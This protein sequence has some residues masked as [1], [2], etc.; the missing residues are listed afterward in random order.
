MKYQMIG[1][2]GI[3]V[4]RIAFGAWEVGGGTAWDCDDQAAGNMVA[5]L[6]D[7]GINF[8]D[9]AKVYGT[10]RSEELLGKALKGKRHDFI[11]ASKGGMN[12]RDS[13]G[14]RF[15]YD[16]DGRSVYQ[17][18]SPK[19]L[20]LDLEESLTRLDTDYLDL[21][22]THRQPITVPIADT[23]GAL[24]RFK[25]EGKIRAIGISNASIPQLEEYLRYGKVDV[26][27][28]KFSLFDRGE[29]LDYISFCKEHGITF[30]AYSALERGILTDRFNAQTAVSPGQ[31][32]Y[33]MIWY[34]TERRKDVLSLLD[35]LKSIAEGYGLSVSALALSYV[36]TW[37]EHINAICGS[38]KPEHLS[39]S[40]LGADLVLPQDTMDRIFALVDAL[41]EKYTD[42]QHRF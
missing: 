1:T 18:T 35:K 22:F 16:R 14:E 33:G 32:A 39:Q 8:I 12:W 27:Q 4:S 36:L 2:S 13:S 30:Q 11:L 29:V 24:M 28:E 41:H 21:Y 31:G 25:E 17:N 6:P 37:G 38:R 26:V 42:S 5:A 40:A 9:T 15:C 7:I 10:G 23:M 20:R 3:E 19:A 34:G